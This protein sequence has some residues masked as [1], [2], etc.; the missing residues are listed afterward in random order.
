MSGIIRLVVGLWLLVGIPN[1]A[2]IN[3]SPAQRIHLD[4]DTCCAEGSEADMD[5]EW[6]WVSDW[7]DDCR[8]AKGWSLEGEP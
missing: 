2:H 6:D 4:E 7:V 5:A 3:T 8:A 1:C